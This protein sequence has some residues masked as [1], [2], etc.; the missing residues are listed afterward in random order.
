MILL[1]I[2]LFQFCFWPLVPNLYLFE[3]WSVP[4]TNAQKH[5]NMDGSKACRDT[6]VDNVK[7]VKGVKGIGSVK[8]IKGVK[9]VEGVKGI[10][11]VKGFEGVNR[12][13]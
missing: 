11:G 4:R 7:G 8:G 2:D 10:E 9:G 13:S 12:I 1:E 5:L 3:S 6:F